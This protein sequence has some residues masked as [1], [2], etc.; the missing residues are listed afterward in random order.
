M[1]AV[2]TL[3]EAREIACEFA[4]DPCFWFDGTSFRIEGALEAG[5]SLPLPAPGSLSEGDGI[6]VSARD[7]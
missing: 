1:A 6:F 7:A 4:Q 3:E 5:W 2:L